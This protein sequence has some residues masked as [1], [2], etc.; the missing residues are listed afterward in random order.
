MKFARRDIIPHL[1]PPGGLSTSGFITQLICILCLSFYTTSRAQAVYYISGSSQPWNSQTNISILNSMFGN[2]WN[3]VNFQNA[4]MNAI[5]QPSTCFVFIEGGDQ[6]SINFSNFLSPNLTALQNWVASGGRLFI[7][8]A[9]N[10]GSNVNFGFGGVTLNYSGSTNLST[11]ANAATG[12]S[13]HPIFTGSNTPCAT[14]YTGNFFAHA[15]ISGG[16]TTALINGLNGPS[17][18]ELTWGS[19]LVMFGGMT[20]VNFHLPSPQ[21]TNLRKNIISYMY[22]CCPIS[23]SASP[24]SICLGSGSSLSGQGALTY[25]WYPGAISSGSILVNP[26]ST[27]VYTVVGTNSV[28]CQNSATV[29]VNVNPPCISVTSTSITCATLGSATVTSNGGIGPFSYT[30]MPSNQSGSVATG[31]SPGIY[32]LTV[33]DFGNNFTYTTTTVFTS[34]VPLSGQLNNSPSVTCNGAATGTAAYTNVS[35][36]S[37]TQNYFW[38]NGIS[39]YTTP[40]VSNLAA[41]L[42]TATITD[43]L[44]GCTVNNLFLILQPSAQT[45]QIAASSPS[46]CA[47]TSV[48]LSGVNNGGTPGYIF[49]WVN[50]PSGNSYTLSQATPGNYVYTLNTQDSYSCPV[51]ATIQLVFVQNP[52]LSINSPSICPLQMGTIT[53]SGA[54]SYSWN[55]NPGTST[56]AD[57]PLTNTQYTVTG[58][59]LGCLSSSIAGIY[60]K[61]VPIPTISSNSPRCQTQS[62]SLTGSGGQ[63]Y[64]WNGPLSFS[65]TLASPVIAMVNPANAGVYQVTVTAANGCTA[66]SSAS[67]IVYSSPSVSATGT[68][69]CINQF[70]NLTSSSLPGASFQWTGPNGFSSFVQNPLLANLSLNSAGQYTVKATSVQGCTNTAIAMVTITA[71]PTLSVSN[72]GPV[73]AG[74]S[75]QL[76]SASNTTNLSYVWTGPNGFTSTQVNPSIPN[77]TLS[78]AGV[79]SVQIT[80]GPCI[81]NATTALT[82]YPLPTASIVGSQTVCET[83]NISLTVNGSNLTAYQWMGPAG[84]TGSTQAV[85]RLFS[86]PSFSGH[87]TVLVNDHHNCQNSFHYSVSVLS[88]PTVSASGTTVCL[89]EPAVLKAEGAAAYAWYSG[90][91]G[92]ASGPSPTIASA[93]SPLPIIY[94]VIGTAVNGCTAMAQATLH[95]RALPVASAS[96]EPSGKH[97][98]NDEVTLIGAGGLTYQW[99]GPN[100]SNSSLGTSQIVLGSM[101]MAGIYTLTVFDTYGCKG[102]TT[103]VI[104]MN[105]LPNGII[106]ADKLKHCVPF[107]STIEF[108]QNSAN[109]SPI[110]SSSWQMNSINIGTSNRFTRTFGLAGNYIIRGTF[111]DSNNCVNSQSITIVAFSKPEADFSFLPERAIENTEP[112]QFYNQSK[113]EGIS[114]CTWFFGYEKAATVSGTIQNPSYTFPLAG[115]YPVALLIETDHGCM[116][117]LVKDVWVDEDVA[118]YVPDAFTP[119]MDLKN[120]VFIPVFR[121]VLSFHLTVYNRWGARIF[122]TSDLR[123]GWDGSYQG[124]PAQEGMYTYQLEFNTIGGKSN[125]RSGSVLLYR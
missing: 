42:W 11:W 22:I 35:G 107:Q 61:P 66:A 114:K 125:V 106:S 67:V 116:D 26:L 76:Q 102:S 43:G 24:S 99:K 84:F 34:N 96:V 55:N 40:S 120:D 14:N 72:S 6:T 110:V 17:L 2:N 15:F 54:T 57:N 111:V 62:L 58:A 39:T 93:T 12:Q 105:E 101:A 103:A 31:L 117:T 80:G 51:S 65:S 7:N 88:N 100:N 28:G 41:G 87:Y 82:I 29:S 91:N 20:T 90:V 45:L 63:T 104:R 122:E 27:S 121:G 59:A 71:I 3:Q 60:L 75:I 53:V 115:M 113:G 77:T 95:T 48:S 1:K 118:L 108:K 81:N 79:Y 16:N 89:Y 98:L 123:Q 85:V 119:N 92:I 64:V 10:Q 124:N 21:A 23:A 13:L 33:H 70:L 86:D 25:T 36:G 18:T 47:G 112:V 44:T 56:F 49:S 50:G 8:A 73:C 37:A 97:C 68:N 30:W 74:Q 19:G 69:V 109:A 4:N 83:K 46:A 94:T 32:T 5:L 78:T 52:V 38:G 9:P